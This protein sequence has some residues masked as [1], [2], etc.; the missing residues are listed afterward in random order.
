[1]VPLDFYS[2]M[3]PS[4]MESAV[5]AMMQIPATFL[6]VQLPLISISRLDVHISTLFSKLGVLQDQDLVNMVIGLL[7]NSSTSHPDVMTTELSPFLGSQTRVLFCHGLRIDVRA[8]SVEIPGEDRDPSDPRRAD[9]TGRSVRSHAESASAV[10]GGSAGRVG[11]RADCRGDEGSVFLS[12]SMIGD[13]KEPATLPE[14]DYKRRRQSYRAKMTHLTKRTTIQEHRDF[15]N[16]RM[17]MLAQ[18]KGY[19]LIGTIDRVTTKTTPLEI[20]KEMRRQR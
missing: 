20:E 16:A 2:R 14:G 18:D 4:D 19:R 15:I 11:D 8:Q 10:G 1:M 12:S 3:D 9:Q 17:R 5:N 6:N 13:A 7:L